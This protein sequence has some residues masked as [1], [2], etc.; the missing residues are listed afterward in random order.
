MLARQ[1]SVEKRRV[2]SR[3]PEPS[4]PCGSRHPALPSVGLP[5]IFLAVDL[6]GFRKQG[7]ISCP[8]FS[9]LSGTGCGTNRYKKS[10]P[11]VYSH[12]GLHPAYLTLDGCHLPNSPWA[13][14]MVKA[15]LL[16]S[17]SP[18]FP[19]LPGR[20]TASGRCEFRS[21][22]QRRDRPRF[23]RDSLLSLAA[24]YGFFT[25]IRAVH[26]NDFFLFSGRRVGRCGRILPQ[27][28]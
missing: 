11:C 7:R 24:P 22:I 1:V 21:R 26:V 4:G 23:S 28:I 27:A 12:E 19:R 10:P 5:F 15:G 18:Y 16:T 25:T 6:N 9:L 8:K 13:W 17:G 14:P 3:P 20:S 2:L